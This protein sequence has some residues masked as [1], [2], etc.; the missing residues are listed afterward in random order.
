MKK[1]F[2]TTLIAGFTAITL[3]G[4]KAAVIDSVQIAKVDTSVTVK[5]KS[6]PTNAKDFGLLFGFNYSQYYLESNPFFVDSL[7]SMGNSKVN[8]NVGL[9]IGVFYNIKLS[10][11]LIL[12]P[13]VEATIMPATIE[14][15]LIRKKSESW[16]YPLTVDLPFYFIYGNHDRETLSKKRAQLNWLAAVRPVI[17]LS[18]M[19]STQPVVKNFNLNIDIGCSVPFVLKSTIMKAEIFYSFG[20]LN[21]IGDDSDNYKT[22]SINSL[23]RNFIGMRFFFN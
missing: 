21:I 20:S 22:S 2:I 13:A 9:T 12:R 3:I 6:G 10:E 18:V 15:D 1:H 17:P 8:N 19:S 14:Y 23:R 5:K 16:I 11:K 7:T 4:Q